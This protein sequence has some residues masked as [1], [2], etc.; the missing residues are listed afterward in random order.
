MAAHDY[1]EG[2]IFNEMLKHRRYPDK[3]FVASTANLRELERRLGV[4]AK[5]E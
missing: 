5:G 3:L 1:R 2:A 4:N